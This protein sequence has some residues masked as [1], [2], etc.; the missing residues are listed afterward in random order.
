MKR[1]ESNKKTLRLL[2][3]ILSFAILLGGLG[4][5]VGAIKNKDASNDFSDSLMAVPKA[6]DGAEISLPEGISEIT[7][8]IFH[9]WALDD[10]GVFY[11]GNS[12][13]LGEDGKP[14]RNDSNQNTCSVLKV[15]VKGSGV[16]SFD[17][18]VSSDT[19]AG[20]DNLI[21]W[22]NELENE[23]DSFKNM[24]K[25]KISGE[26]IR[27]CGDVDWTPYGIRVD[28]D[29]NETTTVFFVYRKNGA[30]VS[31]DDK[32]YIRALGFYSGSAQI[33][34]S[35]NDPSL[36]SIVGKTDPIAGETVTYEAVTKNGSEFYGWNQ[37]GKFVS[38]DAKYS[39]VARNG[40][41][42]TAIFGEKS[43]VVSRNVDTG[44]VY[45]SIDES[46]K[47]AKKSETVMLVA[48]ADIN[49]AVTIPETV[50]L[51][52][53]YSEAYD[54]DGTA[55][56]TKSSETVFAKSSD[57]FRRLSV[58]P[59]S[60]LKVKGKLMLGGII[61]YPGQYYQGHTSGAY[62]KINN[63]GSVV[64]ADGGIF[65]C[66]GFVDGNGTVAAESGASVYE[67]FVVYDFSGGTNTMDLY[68]GGFKNR[69]KTESERGEGKAPFTQ[70]TMQNI[71]CA[72]EINSGATL[73]GR[74]NL[75]AAS[76]FN[77]TDVV[78]I[79]NGEYGLITLK[80][81]ASLLRTV[82]KTMHCTDYCSDLGRVTYKMDGGAEF[83]YM[84]M[85]LLNSVDV[86]TNNILFPIPYGYKYVMNSGNFE[87][88]TDT[89]L[90]PGAEMLVGE[91]A[92]LS[93]KD[94]FIVTDGL[95]QNDLS[96]KR[97]PT[98]EMLRAS[99]FFTN[100]SLVVNGTLF[101]DSNTPFGGIVQTKKLGAKIV[102][103]SSDDKADCFTNTVSLG[104]DT[105][106]DDNTAV[107]TSVG[108]IYSQ[109]GYSKLVSGKTYVAC[110]TVERKL[111]SFTM[112]SYATGT[113][114][115]NIVFREN[116]NFESDASVYG[117][118]ADELEYNRIGD[119]N[120]DSK[121]DIVDLT[122]LQK[123]FAETVSFSA[124]QKAAADI[125]GDGCLDAVDL[126]MLCLRVSN[127]E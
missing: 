107:F 60:T 105:Q 39:L 73:F 96:G 55:D 88:L 52:I 19:Y 68:Y 86:S 21:V 98:T 119:I 36:G 34:L 76:Q 122:L 5:R 8:D 103:E 108:R 77:K 118:F 87:I 106:F 62:G 101:I 56:G 25:G 3:G 66:Y 120:G 17:Y 51:Y 114:K 24:A 58:S 59:L 6:S 72:L 83:R 80:N 71:S 110:D 84:S 85:R 111:E 32:A 126:S 9:P 93:L 45:N 81:G 69:E 48:D 64:I 70:Y 26:C 99:G 4:I 23:Y 13:P 12:V 102:T 44:Y 54:P 50:T 49:G 57:E 42:L 53:P 121:V 38:S 47:A 78:I 28:A 46:L 89:V 10:T 116:E 94:R 104:A 74:C 31:G 97:Y 1:C 79:G 2:A 15:K 29:E 40:I 7:T 124:K 127:T 27:E 95:V 14:L 16:L 123:Y 112:D 75:Y 30:K 35:V 100:G 65:D 41:V 115:E 33:G 11:S 109:N 90:M 92:M 37:N 125:N 91:K 117:S 22:K 113:G 18:K 61:G 63:N 82:D 67:P 20:G 43:K